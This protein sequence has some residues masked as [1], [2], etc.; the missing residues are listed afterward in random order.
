MKQSIKFTLAVLAAVFIFNGAATANP[1]SDFKTNV[2]T[3]YLKPFARDFGGLLGGSDFSSGRAVGFPGFDVGVAAVVQSKPDSDDKILK[4]ADVKAFGF[5]LLQ[6]SVGLPAVGADIAV[7]GMSYS[8][9]SII[10]GGLRYPL[11]KS[12]TLTKFIPD[13]AV[14]A[15]YDTINYTYFK[16]NHMSLDASASLDIPVIKPFAGIGYD[17]TKIEVKDVSAALNGASG[18]AAGMRYTLG[19]K[20]TPFPMTY[21][22][23]AYSILHGVAGYQAGLGVK[24]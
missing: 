6:A 5:P 14:A 15:F 7:R 22:F 10:G 19:L 20:V 16:G 21:V 17:R 23:G 1:F 12:G 8:S 3:A 24:F 4:N 2:G 11:L 13:V 9:L 18:T